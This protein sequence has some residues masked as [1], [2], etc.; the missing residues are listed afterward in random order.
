MPNGINNISPDLRDWLLNKNLILS[1]TITNNGLQGLSVG[2]GQP[3][4][5]ETLPNAVQSST[6]IESEGQF[7]RDLN[8]FY[9]PYKSHNNNE[10]IDIT[11]ASVGNIGNIP[12]GTQPLQYQENIG[13]ENDDSVFNQYAEDGREHLNKN[14]YFDN[15]ELYKVNINS[16]SV[17]SKS[18]GIYEFR[19][20]IINKN[21]NFIANLVGLG[22]VAQN[23]G[24]TIDNTESD[25]GRIANEQVLTH[26]GYNAS[27]GIA[28]EMLGQVNLNPLSLLQGNDI[29][30][31]NFA[32]TVPSGN[33]GRGL[34]YFGRVLGV[35]P[36]LSL[37]EDS[38][39]I[40]TSENPVTNTIRANAQVQNTGKG[41]VLALIDNLN[42]NKYK[43]TIIDDRI[44]E[45]ESSGVRGTNGELYAFESGNGEIKDLL[46]ASIGDDGSEFEIEHGKITTEIN[47]KFNSDF[48]IGTQ[49]NVNGRNEDGDLL[50]QY[51]WGD[52]VNNKAGKQAFGTERRFSTKKSLLYKTES[53]FRSNKM[54]TLV[55]GHGVKNQSKSEIQS[56]VH[57]GYTSKGSGVLSPQAAAPEVYGPLEDPK[58]EDV[59]CR[60]WTT[61][62]RYDNVFDL[63]KNSGLY[64]NAGSTI[65]RNVENSVLDSNGFVR[66][67]PNIGDD[68]NV[69]NVGDTKIK[70]FMFSIENLAWDDDKSFSFL[71]NCEK[72]PG[73]PITG[74]RGRIM[75]FPPYGMNFTD[76]S[77]VNWDTTNFIGRGEPI[78][79]YNNTE[80][81]GTLQW[82]IIIDHPTHINDLR[83]TSAS[84]DIFASI[85]SG[86]MDLNGIIG[87]KLSQPEKDEIEKGTTQQTP[88][89]QADNIP[90]P[91]DFKVYF[92]NDNVSLSNED[93]ENG[94]GE[95]IGD[96]IASPGYVTEAQRGENWR[97]RKYKDD[98]DF[99]LNNC[100]SGDC[101][102]SQNL[103][104]GD[105][106]Y[107]G[108]GGSYL[109]DLVVY[110]LEKAPATK[111]SISGF[112]SQ[113]GQDTE[114]SA[115]QRLSADR[116]KN[117]KQVLQSLFRMS[118]DPLFEERF[119]ITQG[120]GVTGGQKGD[121]DSIE[122]KKAR[123]TKVSFTYDESLDERL[124]EIEPP[125]EESVVPDIAFNIRKRYFNECSYFQKLEQTD[126]FVYKNLKEKVKYFHP[127]FHSITPEGFNARLNFLKQC[128]R[129][130]A[131]LDKDDSRPTNLAF[132]RPPVCI[133]RIGDFYHTKI[134]IDNLNL[135]FDP[136]VW[137]LNPEG[138]GVQPMI[139]T[140]DMSFKFIGGSSLQGPINRL[141]N[142]V[143][144][145]FFGN[146]EI[147][148]ERADFIKKTNGIDINTGEETENEYQIV[149]GV[150]PNNFD[151]PTKGFKNLDSISSG[152]A[153]N[154][155][156]EID[157]E[158]RAEQN[159]TIEEEE[160][161]LQEKGLG[162]FDVN[163]TQNFL[164]GVPDLLEPNI[165]VSIN[166]NLKIGYN[167]DYE[168]DEDIY[169]INLK[170]YRKSNNEIVSGPI[171]LNYNKNKNPEE[172]N[173]NVNIRIPSTDINDIS[174][175][176]ALVATTTTGYRFYGISV[177]SSGLNM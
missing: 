129:Q 104:I 47:D 24:T 38:S 148:D 163:I 159:T 48:G 157:E 105:K 120:E 152:I 4:E 79:T 7:Y 162:M 153:P 49:E 94:D 11:T 77:M 51:S 21:L 73:D 143:S 59:F 177:G 118:D 128:T 46:N 29:F 20:S 62:D 27:F 155:T 141:Q 101:P 90:T 168:L 6:N 96:Y 126:K 54:N 39:S 134:V 35:T 13:S 156:P 30:V 102:E 140:V 31:Q 176:Y 18:N 111:I 72:G 63:Q 115:N 60:T 52:D 37:Y 98:T 158:S 170:V 87:E 117:V 169:I 80:R 5:V 84:D 23:V 145:N 22:S 43:P 8:L 106:T 112:A 10:E 14:K 74:A 88:E 55:T 100:I 67:G 76:N 116:A 57:F 144:F 93:Y 154:P 110:I 19:T 109:A 133:L 53:L 103:K 131:T 171:F 32:I 40:F 26:F 142:A 50:T 70:R 17:A 107:N 45:D 160:E 174:N 124:S 58:A 138:V 135:S 175:K 125:I 83:Q 9:N 114:P 12:L 150:N 56:A 147:Y 122:K 130:G 64:T 34:D 75:W 68:E 164:S 127:S 78:Y 86:C 16:T 1:D 173:K 25:M 113:D 2:L 71:P 85:A 99:G 81:N 69:D 44:S 136:L 149:N 132:G 28:N 172:F 108:W 151:N 166:V 65:R 161:N 119:I 66:I 146:T 41:Q 61:V 139:C 165:D 15:D 95:G 36:P 3:A 121:V 97:T 167:S 42:Q 123:Y 92:P 91:T 137:D 89:T 82:Q 33:L